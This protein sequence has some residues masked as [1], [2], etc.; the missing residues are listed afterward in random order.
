MQIDFPQKKYKTIYVDPP[1]FEHGGGKI[2]RSADRHYELMK[3]DEIK[4]LP[5]GDLA[6]ENGCHIY[7]WATN[8]HLKDAFECLEAWGFDYVTMITWLKDSIGLGQY[9]RGLTEHCL[10]GRTKKNCRSKQKTASDA[11]ASRVFA[12]QNVNTAASQTK[13][14]R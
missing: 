14:G 13:C 2:Q 9:Y 6:D 1:W 5:V 3:T 12:S 8:N 10:F 4:S 7:L 11:R